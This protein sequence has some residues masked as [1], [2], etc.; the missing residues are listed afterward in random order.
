MIAM[1]IK[2]LNKY[3]ITVVIGFLALFLAYELWNYY[4]LGPWTR[5][6]RIRVEIIQTSAQITGRLVGL[7]V[8]DNQEVTKGELLLEI[9]PDDYE[10]KIA[11][12]EAQLGQL[13]AQQILAQTQFERR[14]QL[15]NQSSIS[16]E[17]FDIA[18]ASLENLDNRIKEALAGLEKA[19]LDLRRTRIYAEADG[20]ITNLHIREGNIIQ[21]GQ[22][23]LALVDR[24]SYYAVGY[25]EET[26]MPF[27]AI[28]KKVE[29]LP[30]DGSEKMTGTIEGFGRAIVDQ[31]AST[32]SQLVQNVQPNY[33]W[34]TL[35]QRIPVR[36]TLDKDDLR[37]R[38]HDLIAGSTCTIVIKD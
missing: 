24:D 20:Y 35:A 13:K 8:V 28:G 9:E 4:L 33:P 29:I 14:R 36:V 16:T 34:V 22:P 21:A 17:D 30:Y 7:N 25:F 11:I 6:G 3:M 26:K 1:K 10:I 19:R 15:L 23:L 12:A 32:G 5:D 31:S 18:K 27:I 38:R 37:K 2:I